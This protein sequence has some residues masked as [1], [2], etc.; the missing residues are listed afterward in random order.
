MHALHVA[1]L[2]LRP[3]LGDLAYHCALVETAIT[4][5]PSTTLCGTDSR[6]S[7][8]NRSTIEQVQNHL[9]IQA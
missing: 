5:F 7:L 9:R 6:L 3:K 8:A 4:I 2:H 1:L